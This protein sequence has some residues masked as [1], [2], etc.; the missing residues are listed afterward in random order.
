MKKIFRALPL[1][2]WVAI[3]L[4]DTAA[5]LQISAML[6]DYEKESN[7]FANNALLPILAAGFALSALAV[8]ISSAFVNKPKA[9]PHS[10]SRFRMLHWSPAVGFLC[11]MAGISHEL[12]QNGVTLWKKHTDGQLFLEEYLQGQTNI[13]LFCL[14]LLILAFVFCV[15]WTRKPDQ[16]DPNKTAGFG[17]AAVIACALLSVLLYFDMSTEMNAPVKSLLQAGFL[18]SMIFFTT[19]LRLLLG[20]PLPR[21]LAILSSLILTV[22]SLTAL[23]ISIAYLT[24]RIDRFSH[25]AY[26]LFMLCMIPVAL[27]HIIELFSKN[28]SQRKDPEDPHSERTAL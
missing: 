13:A 23:P 3:L 7:Y 20:K 2:Q 10:Q 15:L 14:L 26:A 19:E 4:A 5:V 11:A 24:Q 25:F 28:T 17:F 16:A 22:G 18:S 1:L 6:L 8:G 9:F 12:I 21:L 27:G